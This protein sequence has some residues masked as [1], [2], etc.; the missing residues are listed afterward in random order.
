LGF[1]R[2]PQDKHESS[3]ILV[4]THGRVS[5]LGLEIFYTLQTVFSSI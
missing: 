3:R 2:K 5:K 1:K 4:E